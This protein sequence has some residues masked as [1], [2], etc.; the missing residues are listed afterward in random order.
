[1]KQPIKAGDICK[2]V[3]GLTRGKSPNIG[4]TVTVGHRIYG[5]HGMDH[6]RFGPVHA[7]TGADICQ[8]G[9]NGEFVKTG[10]ADF[11]IEWLE[12]IEPPKLDL[13]SETKEELS[14]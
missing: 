10:Q 8:L 6:S 14:A 2:V 1:M 12:K 5:D 3:M 4:K 7:C 9:E 13:K 11:P